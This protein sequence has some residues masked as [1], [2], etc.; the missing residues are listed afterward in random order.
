[1]K[2][3]DKSDEFKRKTAD[4]IDRI[5][6]SMANDIQNLAKMKVPQK[7][8]H[9]Q[10]SIL[11]KRKPGVK[12]AW[13]VEAAKE[14][15]RFQEFGGDGRRVVRHYST[16]GT[17]KFYLR[18]SGRQVASNAMNYIRKELNAGI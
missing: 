14:Y 17:G 4:R 5:L 6:F 2:I 1:M 18:D 13:M 15:A 7:Q 9:L 10:G 3:I 16:P 8:G 12:H 11:A